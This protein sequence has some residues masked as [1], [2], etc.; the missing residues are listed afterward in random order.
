MAASLDK[1]METFSGEDSSTSHQSRRRLGNL[2][3]MLSP[4]TDQRYLL[5]LR[6]FLIIQTVLWVFLQTFVPAAVKGSENTHG[7]AYQLGFRKSLSVL[8]WNE[9]L[10]YSFFILLSARSIC[11]PFLKSS[12]KGSVASSCFRRSI[13][14]FFPV[15]VAL[16]IVKLTFD[17]VGT[18]YIDD[19]KRLTGN[20]SIQTPYK[21]PNPL[22]YM[23]SVFNL[24]WTT[25]DFAT[26]AG[27]TAF[28]SQTMWVLNVIYMQSYTV[29]MAMIIIPY[30]RAAWRIEAWIVFIVTAWWVQSWAWYTVTGIFFA[31]AVM[32]MNFM[33]GSKRGMPIWKTNI[34]VPTWLIW[35]A[36]LA[37]GLT[38]QFA[39][40]TWRPEAVNIELKG[41]TGLYY[42]A[43]L[44]HEYDLIQPQARDDN[45]L[46]ILGFFLM[47]ETTEV[48]QKILAN[49]VF[50]YLGARSLSMFSSSIPLSLS[51]PAFHSTLRLRL[52]P[53]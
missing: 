10:L 31:D 21:M 2:S 51:R 6:G 4:V 18:S 7:P 26:Q 42:T 23:N 53:Q 44:N 22:V 19:F 43:G 52:L 8:F 37:G 49:P 1:H 28:P 48:V 29:Y 38:M 34:R 45:Y 35:P 47:M 36:L 3:E 13:R 46:I 39:W 20:V 11:I 5:G 12:T 9:E 27:N 32:N 33:E 41:H 40:V 16:A 15:A 17:N 24:F 14:I 25:F 50:M 30:T